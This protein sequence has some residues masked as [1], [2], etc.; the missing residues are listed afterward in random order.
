ME[1]AD[2]STEMP[3]MLCVMYK[4]LIMPSWFWFC[5]KMAREKDLSDLKRG[6]MLGHGREELPSQ[7]LL[8]LLV[9]QYEQWLECHLH[10]DLWERL[11]NRV[12]NCCWHWQ[13]TFDDCDACA[14]VRRKGKTKEQLFFGWLRMSM[15]EMNTLLVRTVT[16]SNYKG[17]KT[18]HPDLQI[19]WQKL[20]R[21]ISQ[22]QMNS[23]GLNCLIWCWWRW[24]N[25]FGTTWAQNISV[26]M[27]VGCSRLTVT[28]SIVH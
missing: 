6:F 8:S 4:K 3:I 28:T 5:I 9:S 16:N 21:Q 23:S 13:H 25:W 1:N 24:V 19:C 14:L 12:G 26:Q 10:L 15:P 22:G 18:I 11:V 2:A 7:R 27:D 20:N 17:A